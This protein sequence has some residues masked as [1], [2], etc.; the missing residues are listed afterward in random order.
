MTENADSVA[1]FVADLR[2]L[3][4]AAGS[5]TLA[6][7][8]HD[9]GISRTVLSEAFSGRHLP[10]TRTVDGIARACG[11]DPAAWIDRRDALAQ[12][13]RAATAATAETPATEGAGEAPPAVPERAA[14]IP[15]RTAGWLMAAAFLVGALVSGTIAAVIA[16]QILSA[17]T[18]GAAAP[19][20]EV[21]SGEDPALTACVDDARVVSGD[22]RADSL[23]LEVVWSDKCQAGWDGPDR[24]EATE[25]DVPGAYTALVVRPSPDTLLCAEGSVTVDGTRIDLGEPLCA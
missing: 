11:G 19:Q 25:H 20:I 1:Q 8:Q 4:L 24:Q 9:T 17:Q 3:R 13:R 21:A 2:K 6:R 22:A 10:S 12:A 23:L 16:T 5:P 7:L 15:R 14:S 18:A